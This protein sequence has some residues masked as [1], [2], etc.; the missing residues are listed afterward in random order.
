M[1][2]GDAELIEE[3]ELKRVLHSGITDEESN[4]PLFHLAERSECL[5]SLL[6][7]A[8]QAIYAIANSIHKPAYQPVQTRKVRDGPF[9]LL[10]RAAVAGSCVCR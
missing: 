3:E 9:S 1:Y 2:A 10:A 6:F 4:K 7:I 8:M 5:S